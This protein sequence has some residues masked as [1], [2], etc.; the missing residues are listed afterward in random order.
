M[1][2]LQSCPDVSDLQRLL[3]GLLPEQDQADLNAHLGECAACQQRLDDLI[4]GQ[5][6]WSEVARHLKSAHADIEAGTA[7]RCA[8]RPGEA[9]DQADDDLTLEFLQPSDKP[10]SLGRL[11]HYEVLEVIGRGGMGIVLRAFDEK[12]HRVVAM[13]VMA[14]RLAATSP[15]RK[16]FLREARAAAQVRHEHVVDIHA[17]EE[18]PIPHLVMEYVPGESL[19]QRLNRIGPL[20]VHDVLRIGQQIARGL[21]AAHAQGLIHRDVKPGN[22]LLEKG[23]EE[24]VKITDFGL[25]RAADD[26]SLT[27]SG[28]IAGT[29]LFMA[30][31]QAQGGAIDH[32]ADL[33]SLGSVL[34]TMA[35]G[36]P[37]FRAPTSLA[38]LKRVVE[39]TPRPIQEIIPEVPTWLCDIIARLHAKRPEDR[40]QSAK[41]VADLLS[42][43]QKE[44]EQHGQ[45]AP[46]AGALPVASTTD[47]DSPAKPS[48]SPP[49]APPKVHIS[50]SESVPWRMWVIAATA[51]L[52]LLGVLSLSEATGVTRVA[53]T[54][55]HLLTAQG[56][57]VIETNDPDVNVTI[58]G[59]GGLVITGAGLH[60]VRLKPGSYQ[61][62]ADKNGQPVK[63]DQDLVTITR[64]DKQI[65]R[66]RLEIQPAS[67]TVPKVETGAFV[68]LSGKE[69][70]VRKFDTL[71][72]AALAAGF[73]DTIEI[74]GNGPYD[75]EPIEIRPDGLAI[76]AAEGFVPVLRLDLNG[77]QQARIQPNTLLTTLGQGTLTLEGLD[78]QF[79]SAGPDRRYIDTL[80]NFDGPTYIANC[81]LLTDGKAAGIGLGRPSNLEIRNTLGVNAYIRWHPE[82]HIVADNCIFAEQSGQFLFY[83]AVARAGSLRLTHNT[84]V[85]GRTIIVRDD[86]GSAGEQGSTPQLD[87]DTSDNVFD[88]RSSL[89]QWD[90]QPRYSGRPGSSQP[91]EAL[92]LLSKHM[93]WREARNG[94][95][96][97]IPL[98]NL[99]LARSTSLV[100]A[101]TALADWNQFWGLTETGAIQG[102]F[103]YVG[104]DVYTR[105]HRA[106]A[107]LAPEDFCL[108]AGSTGYRAGPDGRNLGA[109]VDLVGPG[110]AYQ[111]WKRTPEYQQWLL[112]TGRQP[113]RTAQI[114][115]KQA[116]VVL[117]DSE[118]PQRKFDA[119]AEAVAAA[120]VGGT[121]EIRGNGP[122]AGEPIAVDGAL[123]IR[124]GAGFRPVFHVGPVENRNFEW[125]YS[126]SR[127]VLEGL[128]FHGTGPVT[129]EK[130]AI[131]GAVVYSKSAP[132]YIANCRFVRRV[133]GNS[134]SQMYSPD[135]RLLNCQF[136]GW[137]CFYVPL[138][139]PMQVVLQ[140][141][142]IVGPPGPTIGFSGSTK[143]ASSVRLIRNTLIGGF[144]VEWQAAPGPNR[145]DASEPL[146]IEAT[147]N[148]FDSSSAFRA[149]LLNR[150]EDPTELLKRLVHWEGNHNLFAPFAQVGLSNGGESVLLAKGLAQWREFWGGTDDDSSDGGSIR[151]ARG[152]WLATA[153]AHPEELQPE[154]FR[155]AD[156]DRGA[157]V[158]LVGPGPAYERWKQTP[159]YQEWLKDTGQSK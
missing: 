19:Q 101:K 100:P 69:V 157:D 53:A 15:P 42:R 106:P 123:C 136:S 22:I 34:Y 63:L 84:L 152:S 131:R 33:F 37:P 113:E 48:E 90:T 62:K 59:D 98:I 27:Q 24:R 70:E 64:G 45:V 74:R 111:R 153:Q 134:V 54:I 60:E 91:A 135:C 58:E 159:E 112:R 7:T 114:S 18:L 2:E 156:D 105:L 86:F 117:G 73:G 144:G 52:L 87:C 40:Y 103:Y 49:P 122:F 26:A 28:V 41:E 47:D 148:V 137:P 82:T 83:A 72:A 124:A 71:A 36:R 38:V 67:A 121:V 43:C 75:T 23:V 20:E 21:A 80:F 56:T 115:Q 13:K 120:P 14:P 46:V 119:L 78:L 30:P 4:A 8:A 61:L 95:R 132:L 16:R 77:A 57:L 12:L 155:L 88:A 128:E 138:R 65:V 108:R 17:V 142:V 32:R 146:S 158:D 150:V 25:A 151:Y 110:A 89:L 93:T 44:Y 99:L 139:N 126:E 102:T 133:S 50:R 140:N 97:E 3:E 31:E 68:L 10:D 35:S 149:L 51:L 129:L 104:G 92:E 94:Y 9:S 147:G 6:F 107:E 79:Q 143:Q 127:L 81:R 29:P 154:D 39:D 109:N 76:R 5:G 125:L 130:G 55:I 145:L 118:F 96:A 116:F 66:V 1:A 85:G 141:N 11:A